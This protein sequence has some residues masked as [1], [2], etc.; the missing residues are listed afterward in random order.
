MARTPGI[1]ILSMWTTLLC[2]L[3][4]LG[5]DSIGESVDRFR[6]ELNALVDEAYSANA[7]PDRDRVVGLHQ[8]FF[9]DTQSHQ[10]YDNHTLDELAA[11]HTAT[12]A[13]FFYTLSPMLL[14]RLG[15]LVIEL[16]ERLRQDD[17]I[18]SNVE[19][20]YLEEFHANLL[21][22]RRFSQAQEFAERYELDMSPWN[23]I[24]K[25]TT[26]AGPAILEIDP[27]Q[28]S[29]T[30]M[31]T[32]VDLGSGP[33]VVAVVHPACA[34]SA[35]AMA[36]IED[37]PSLTSLFAGRTV[38]LGD[39]GRSVPL[40]LI[41][42]WNAQSR[43][44]KIAIS[45]DNYAW[46]PEIDFSTPAFYFLRDGVIRDIVIGWPGPEQAEQLHAAFDAIGVDSA[47]APMSH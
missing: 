16:A 47:D 32:R 12:E 19:Q 40:E 45:Y 3:A 44:I 31:R 34:F 33:I 39:A 7:R 6:V 22:A 41:L 30:L 35:R 13:A 17:G 26:G 24:D 25:T 29:V 4:A 27:N 46:P 43:V 9:A 21:R 15:P 14:D 28:T 1:L 18:V 20:R 38:W 42:A 36:Y 37:N 23:V 8:T 5:E 2:P 11:L 10:G